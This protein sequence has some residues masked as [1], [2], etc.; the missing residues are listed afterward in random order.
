MLKEGKQSQLHGLSTHIN[1]NFSMCAGFPVKEVRVQW[2]SLVSQV[3]QTWNNLTIE[4]SLHKS[5]NLISVT[6]LCIDYMLGYSRG[7][8]LRYSKVGC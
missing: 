5:M 2:A 8:V 6:F 3:K 1:C 7:R 4:F